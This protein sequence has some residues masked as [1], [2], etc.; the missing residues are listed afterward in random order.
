MQKKEYQYKFATK[1]KKYKSKA[2]KTREGF[3][4]QQTSQIFTAFG[5]PCHLAKGF[6]EGHAIPRFL[7]L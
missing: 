5:S 6:K 2:T 4:T 3:G 7:L 1:P